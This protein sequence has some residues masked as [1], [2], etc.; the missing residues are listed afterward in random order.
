MS[1]VNV[2]GFI[3]AMRIDVNC[4]NIADYKLRDQDGDGAI[5]A[6]A[7]DSLDGSF[8]GMAS[9]DWIE[10]AIGIFENALVFFNETR[11]SETEQNYAT[12]SISIDRSLALQLWAKD[13]VPQERR[14][15]LPCC[16]KHACLAGVREQPLP[17]LFL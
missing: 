8:T 7:H 3:D 2:D 1:D 15:I 9:E 10:I 12:S 13:F 6:I 16:V 14:M 5:G 11:T 4:D 17:I